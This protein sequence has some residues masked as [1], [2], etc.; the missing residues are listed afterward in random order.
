MPWFEG[1]GGLC[2]WMDMTKLTGSCR[3][4]FPKRK[5]DHTDI[6]NAKVI[7]CEAYLGIVCYQ[8]YVRKGGNMHG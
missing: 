2:L 1:G 5:Y 7:L 3:V 4:I 6:D 8:K